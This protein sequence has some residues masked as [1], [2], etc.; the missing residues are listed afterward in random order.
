MPV[1]K[2]QEFLKQGIVFG[3]GDFGGRVGVVEDI[4]VLN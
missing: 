1:F 4:V 2:F 3:I